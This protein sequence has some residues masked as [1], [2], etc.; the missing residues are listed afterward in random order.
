MPQKAA[1]MASLYSAW[2]TRVGVKSWFGAQTPI[3][4]TNPAARYSVDNSLPVTA[5]TS[6]SNNA[7]ILR[8]RTFT[9]QASASDNVGV[10]RVEF[11]VNTARVCTD[12][13]KPYSCGWW[14]PSP[15]NASYKLQSKAF[16]MVGNAGASTVVTV[17]AR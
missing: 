15:W 8:N 6:P 1:A 14:V 17:V 4:W 7:T 10:A 16:D 2:A 12:T 3:G 5:I 11:Y 13:V 9:I